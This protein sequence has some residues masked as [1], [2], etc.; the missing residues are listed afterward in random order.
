MDFRFYCAKPAQKAVK[1]SNHRLG[2]TCGD[3]KTVLMLNPKYGESIGRD[4]RKMRIKV[5][6]LNVGK[7]GGYRLI[8]RERIQDESHHIVF[9]W[10]FFK[11]DQESTTESQEK[12]LFKLSEEILNDPLSV[13]WEECRLEEENGEDGWD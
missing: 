7:S 6:A 3:L 4:L 8:Y 2:D 1:K 10:A 12:E 11:G 13:K 5:P 9:L